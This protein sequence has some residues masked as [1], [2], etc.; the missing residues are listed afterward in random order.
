MTKRIIV[1][2]KDFKM[3]ESWYGLMATGKNKSNKKLYVW[4]FIFNGRDFHLSFI[5]KS[6]GFAIKVSDLYNWEHRLGPPKIIFLY[7]N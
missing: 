7:H 6:M 1:D 2:N 4:S 5:P 3:W